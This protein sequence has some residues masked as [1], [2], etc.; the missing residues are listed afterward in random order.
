MK[1]RQLGKSNMIVSELG[2]GCM[3]MSF[4]YGPPTDKPQ[5]IQVIR[6]AYEKGITLF[7]T[8]EVYA[9]GENEKLV[10]EA[11]APF[12][13]DVSVCTKFG[14]TPE[15]YPGLNSRPEHIR[16]VAE[17]SLKRLRTDRIDLFYQHRV[18]PSVPPE[19]V[20]GA[21]SELIKEGKIRHYGLS[22]ASADF[23]RRAHA[24]HPVTAVQSE[25]SLWMRD[26]ERDVLPLCEV[27]G[28]GFVSWSPVGAGYLTGQMMPEQSFDSKTDLRARTSRFTRAAREKNQAFLTIL[29]EIGKKKDAT[30][31]Q[32]A[33]AWLLANKPWIVP[34]PGT[35]REDH[36]Q[37][38][39]N[40]VNITLTS[41]DMR[42]INEHLR[43]IQ[44]T[45]QRLPEEELEIIRNG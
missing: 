15:N 11:I 27:L 43:H 25:Y 16:K 5:S 35:T 24:V 7:D 10:G 3:S 34:I 20:A 31:V 28:I 19:D 30:P 32:I 6:S 37:E 38:N 14:F 4:G 1:K 33:L 40:A 17:A 9:A 2:L 42:V 13:N 26:R 23:I 39:L 12:R 22:E 44:V 18:D 8:A 29:R 36:L 21:L 41:D 45:G